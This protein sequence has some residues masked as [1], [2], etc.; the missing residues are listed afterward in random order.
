MQHACEQGSASRT[1][2]C[3]AGACALQAKGK[4]D[5]RTFTVLVHAAATA[6]KRDLALSTYQRA[7]ET[8]ISRSVFLYTAAIGA[9]ATSEQPADIAAALQIYEDMLR[10]VQ[11]AHTSVYYKHLPRLHCS[12]C[13]LD[14]CLCRYSLDGMPLMTLT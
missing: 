5:E 10:C 1:T 4:A 7:V 6:G 11:N 13:L 8:G 14:I 12:T 3:I 2:Y 9:C